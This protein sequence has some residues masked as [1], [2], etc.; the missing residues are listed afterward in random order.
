MGNGGKIKKKT[1]IKRLNKVQKNL[2]FLRK[3]KNNDVKMINQI[4]IKY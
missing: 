3:K 4:K 1:K 2:L